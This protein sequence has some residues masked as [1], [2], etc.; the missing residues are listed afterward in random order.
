[1]AKLLFIAKRSRPD[2][3]L[4][5]AFLST[6]VL[7]ST[8]QDH[9]KLQRVLSYLKGNRNFMLRLDLQAP[10]QL[11]AYTDASHAT[12]D[13][14]VS[15]SGA[16]VFV[17][18][19][20]VY[21]ASRK[22]HCVSLSSY[23]AELMALSEEGKE[24]VWCQDFLK[25]QTGH[26]VTAILR[27]DNNGLVQSLHSDKNQSQSN[28]KHIETRFFWMR[29]NIAKRSFQVVFVPTEEQVADFF[30]KPLQGSLFRNL[31]DCILKQA[32]SM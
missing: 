27:C 15:Q 18:G 26:L 5:V 6:R 7:F 10:E 11:L 13:G 20:P 3:L 29:D 17:Y 28:A 21:V 32:D 9:E 12:Q 22:Q 31:R 4:A 1:V 19:L 16:V 8:E 30:T 24:V 2:I 23:E 14:R 25:S